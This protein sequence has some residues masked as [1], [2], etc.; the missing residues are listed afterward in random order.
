MWPSRTRFSLASLSHERTS[1]MKAITA[2]I[3]RE[4]NQVIRAEDVDALAVWGV[5]GSG[6]TSVMMQRL[7][8]LFFQQR[9]TLDAS[10]VFLISP[11]PVFSHYISGVLPDMGERNPQTF[12]WSR[13]PPW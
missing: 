12:T 7:A 1:Q 9:E 5:A 8:Y 6:K 2:T 11:N 13:S 10:R 3:Q 4:Q